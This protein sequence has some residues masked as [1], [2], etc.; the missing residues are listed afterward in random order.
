MTQHSTVLDEA[1]DPET[2]EGSSFDLLPPNKYAAEIDDARVATTK[3][4]EGQ[5]VN[6]RWRIVEGDYESRMVFQSILIQHTSADAQ[7]IGRAKFK[8]V[9]VACDIKDKITDLDVLKY[10]KCTIGVGIEKDRDGVYP[11]KNV[12]KYIKP[13]IANWNGDGASRGNSQKAAT[14]KAAPG[15]DVGTPF[16]DAINF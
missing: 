2:E 1:F 10:K 16:D 12:V 3:N 5:M 6:L 11:D 7:R 8:D 15:K 14:A 13:Y 4:G 9:A